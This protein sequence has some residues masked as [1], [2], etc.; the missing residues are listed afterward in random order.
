MSQ[1]ILRRLTV[2]L[3]RAAVIVLALP[4]IA[5]AVGEGWIGQALRD[6]LDSLAAQHADV[7]ARARNRVLV[8][9]RDARNG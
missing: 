9:G 1:A 6:R 2:S 5:R 4:S 3:S 7:V 8:N